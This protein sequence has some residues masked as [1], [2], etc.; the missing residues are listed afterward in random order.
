MKDYLKKIVAD[1]EFRA[2]NFMM[3]Q[4]LDSG[5]KEF[6][7]FAKDMDIVQPKTTIYGVTTLISLY[8]FKDSRFYLNDE[9][10]KRINIALDY[11]ARFQREDGTFDYLSCNFYSAP[12][13]AFCVK[14]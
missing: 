4:I 11:I 8:N 12:D 9:V 7:G 5:S 14:R 10:L 1:A 13:T 2:E 6:G 3:N